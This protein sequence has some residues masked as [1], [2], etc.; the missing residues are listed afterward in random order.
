MGFSVSQETWEKDQKLVREGRKCVCSGMRRGLGCMSRATVRA[1]QETWTY[2]EDRAAGKP[3]TVSVVVYC[4]RHAKPEAGWLEGTNYR[5]LS[6]E[7][8]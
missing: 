4:S 2:A 8:F 6:V 5:T 7:R 3:P 1:T